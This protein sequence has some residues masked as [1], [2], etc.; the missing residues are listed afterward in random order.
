MQNFEPHNLTGQSVRFRVRDVHMPEPV[1]VLEELHARDVLEGTVVDVS[2]GG[3][4]ND[5]F[6]LVSVTGL[7]HPC[8]VAVTRILSASTSDPSSHTKGGV[9]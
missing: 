9:Q 6:A 7:R 3:G 1:S 5:V 8:I 2:D 4:V